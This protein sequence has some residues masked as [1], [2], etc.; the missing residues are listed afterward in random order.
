MLIL[1]FISLMSQKE[2]LALLLHK[3]LYNILNETLQHS[4]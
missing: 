4:R 1:F 3:R 2:L